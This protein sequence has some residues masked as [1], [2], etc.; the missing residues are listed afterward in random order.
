MTQPRFQGGRKKRHP[1]N[2]LA[3]GE[4]KFENSF[5][6][7]RNPGIVQ[8]EEISSNVSADWS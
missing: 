4:L 7:E 3:D 5:I 2:Q 1:E 8:R 6:V